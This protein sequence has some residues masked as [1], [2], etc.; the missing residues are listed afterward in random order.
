MDFH[1]LD[2]YKKSQ[3]LAAALLV[4]L[5]HHKPQPK[6]SPDPQGSIYQPITNDD[7]NLPL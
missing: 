3:L 5:N 6:L 4:S 2:W 7:Q 1:S